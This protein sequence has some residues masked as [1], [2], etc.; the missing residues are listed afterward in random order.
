MAGVRGCCCYWGWSC[1]AA[2]GR[3]PSLRIAHLAGWWVVPQIHHHPS[4]I[5]PF[6]L[7]PSSVLHDLHA[8]AAAAGARARVSKPHTQAPLATTKTRATGAGR[9][10]TK[11]KALRAAWARRRRRR[12]RRTSDMSVDQIP[13]TW[14]SAG[15][16][17]MALATLGYGYGPW[18]H[19]N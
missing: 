5:H 8:P 3:W 14:S 1:G 4:P 7:H 17:D 12:R 13:S 2:R 19:P 9:G 10:G 18:P 6:I 15:A 11:H 16:L